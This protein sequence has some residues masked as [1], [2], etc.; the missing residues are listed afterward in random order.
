MNRHTLPYAS[1]KRR[2]EFPPAGRAVGWASVAIAAAVIAIWVG[3]SFSIDFGVHGCQLALLVF[4]GIAA[5]LAEAVGS[6]GR[7]IPALI[8]CATNAGIV[9]FWVIRAVLRY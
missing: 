4:V 1:P 2:A 7:S 6:G 3:N 8:G 5:G 9:V